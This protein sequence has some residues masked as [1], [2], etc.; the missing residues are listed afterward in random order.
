MKKNIIIGV[1]ATLLVTETVAIYMWF[2]H[3]AKGIQE[4]FGW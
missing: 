4:A 3:L 1:L 2:N